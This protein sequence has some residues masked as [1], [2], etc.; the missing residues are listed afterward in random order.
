M[1]ARRIVSSRPSPALIVAVVAL[2]A[3]VAGTAIAGPGASTSAISKSKVKKIANKQIN[4][5]LP[6]GTGD[7]ANGAVTGAK[8]GDG[9]LEDQDLG[10]VSTGSFNLGSVTA[11]TCVNAANLNIAG[12]DE[13]DLLLVTPVSDP[14]VTGVPEANF[15]TGGELVMHGIPHPGESHVKVCNVSGGS[16]DP[17]EAFFRAVLIEG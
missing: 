17:G 3:A 6:L 8:V 4:K 7:I 12:A 1:M 14:S 9:S 15:D 11:G 10:V 16:I 13:Q 5:R 2:V